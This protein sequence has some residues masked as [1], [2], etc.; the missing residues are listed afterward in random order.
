MPCL[1]EPAVEQVLLRN[2]LD[3]L[4]LTLDLF[5]EII[6]EYL[7]HVFISILT[8]SILDDFLAHVF[9]GTQVLALWGLLCKDVVF[10]LVEIINLIYLR[11]VPEQRIQYTRETVFIVHPLLELFLD[12]RKKLLVVEIGQ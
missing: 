2:A 11:L 8:H 7:F 10:D 1:Q 5:E 6:F 12:Q 3:F 9:E 4:K